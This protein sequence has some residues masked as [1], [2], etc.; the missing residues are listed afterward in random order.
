M[1]H[2]NEIRLYGSLGT[3]FGRRHHFVVHTARQAFNALVVLRPGFAQALATSHERGVRFAVFAGRDNLTQ[4]D[5]DQPLGGQP[6]RI[7]P[8]IAG[9][10]VDGLWQTIGGAALFTAG[11]V[12]MFWGNPY[13][14]YMMGLGASLTLGG[15]AQMI[16]PH[17]PATHRAVL[18]AQ[19]VVAQGGPVP[20]LYGRMRVGSTLISAS[21]NAVDVK[22]KDSVTTGVSLAG[23]KTQDSLFNR[24]DLEV[25][26]LICEGPIAGPIDATHECQSV[27]F[28]GVP[29]ER[30]QE[31]RRTF[32]VK[33]IAF[34][35]GTLDQRP[36]DWLNTVSSETVVGVQLHPDLPW[37]LDL[38]EADVDEVAI[39]LEVHGLYRDDRNKGERAS[40]IEYQIDIWMDN[41]VPVK[42]IRGSFEGMC[43]QTYER[44]ISVDLQRLRVSGAKGYRIKVSRLKSDE[45]DQ[46]HKFGTVHVASY[47]KRR[48]ARLRYPMSAAVAISMSSDRAPRV[49]VRTY[50]FKGLIVNV[51]SNYDTENR[52]CLGDWDGRFKPA[53]TD[54]PA[55]IFYD[56]L[57]NKRYGAGNWI[58]ESSV[59]RYSL[60]AIGKYCDERVTD[61]RGGWECRFSCNCY[62]TSR[63]HAFALL[64]QLASVFRGMAYWSDGMVMSVADMPQ[65]PTHI[66]V[67]ANVIEGKFRYMGSSLKTRYTVAMVNWHDPDNE[68]REC[69]ESVEDAPGV[70]RYGANKVEV[71]AFGCT[72]RAQAQRVGHWFLLTSRLETDTVVFDVGFDGVRAQPGQI[73]A[74]CDPERSQGGTGGRISA[75]LTDRQLELD[76][77]I[78]ARVPG[79][80]RV[81]L[82]DGTTHGHRVT[83]IAE[84]IVELA[85]P[86]TG[87]PINGAV[88]SYE[89]DAAE[90]YLFRVASVSEAEDGTRLTITATQHESRKF[91]LVD[92]AT[93]V[94]LMPDPVQPAA[95]VQNLMGVTRCYRPAFV[96]VLEVNWEGLPNAA[97][98][99]V[100]L[101]APGGSILRHRSVREPHAS[102][103]DLLPGHYKIS[104][105]ATLKD[106]KRTR[107]AEVA[108]V[109][110][111][112]IY[113]RHLHHRRNFDSVALTCEVD[114]LANNVAEVEAVEYAVARTADFDKSQRKTIVGRRALS[115]V[116]PL[117]SG[118]EGYAWV[119]V[120]SKR[121]DGSADSEWYPPESGAGIRLPPG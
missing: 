17:L 27:Y 95:P 106:G 53:W 65:D 29:L 74:V 11:A 1:E 22:P 25:V 50:D 31:K 39:T 87:S 13:A 18:Q 40:K 7:V 101:S 94:D 111:G 102:L 54:N 32:E 8:V 76:R 120:R 64:Q 73:V 115:C 30:K 19:N 97:E 80:L 56:L 105:V 45:K 108:V 110:H 100:R 51:P 35:Y 2:T 21:T 75:V 34:L 42:S 55:W 36:P 44:T 37:T 5:L 86:L 67:P 79:T 109:L 83:Q 58:N 46:K 72:S 47:A 104:V 91:T 6:V 114:T 57:L 81:V 77:S 62:I 43:R 66:Y 78:E 14:C 93:V 99:D 28:D 90:R 24:V 48:L 20:L 26:D 84:R 68:Y 63:T 12:S 61:G 71:A 117:E 107:E 9:S 113:P 69:V 112:V 89:S 16:S 88:W 49:P 23:S 116:A 10:K 60:Y 52:T 82:P 15:I 98:Y 121:Q 118:K 119:R 33:D 85:T 3:E 96:P 103:V 92:S 59:D 70:E 41:R 4:T 38:S